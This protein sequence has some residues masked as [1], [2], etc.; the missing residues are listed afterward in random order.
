MHSRCDKQIIL[1]LTT[2]RVLVCTSRIF[3][4][5]PI[6]TAVVS[7]QMNVKVIIT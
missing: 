1:L 4:V 2:V 3:N 6:F 5:I 7:H